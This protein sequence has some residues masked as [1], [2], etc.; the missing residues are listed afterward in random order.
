MP[1]EKPPTIDAN[2]PLQR[3]HRWIWV[4][5]MCGAL[6]SILGSYVISRLGC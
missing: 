2:S 5:V 3:G 4:P 1:K 6:L